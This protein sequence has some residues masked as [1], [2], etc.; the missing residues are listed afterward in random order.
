M[1]DFLVID[2]ILQMGSGYVL[3]FSDVSFAQFFEEHGID[4]DEPQYSQM[5]TSKA[6]RLRFFLKTSQPSVAGAILTAL[7]EHRLVMP[8]T[9]KPDAAVVDAYRRI[10]VRLLGP[11]AGAATPIRQEGS[12][13]PPKPSQPIR[14]HHAELAVALDKLKAE[15]LELQAMADRQKAGKLFESFLNRLFTLFDLA[16]TK[17]FEVTGEQI[18]GAF[19]LDTHVYLVEAKWHHDRIETG[20]LF[21]FRVKIEGK[22]AFTRGV[23]ISVSGFTSGG[24]EAIRTNKQA[25][26]LMMDGAHLYRV[27]TGGDRLDSMLRDL[28]RLWA[29]RG[30]PYIPVAD[31]GSAR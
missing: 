30:D 4:I 26:F 2:E 20:E 5:G 14:T 8:R 25:N 11:K 19:M 24:Q 7:L 6:K 27:L 29:E 10:L 23:F 13:P 18:D 22:T 17:P 3:N 31:L 1:T 12:K 15:F 28:V 16:P 9:E 21:Q